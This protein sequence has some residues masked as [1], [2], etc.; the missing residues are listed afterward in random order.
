[1]D[2]SYV[3]D[4]TGW[5]T[6]TIRGDGQHATVTASYLHDSLKNLASA[7][8]LLLGGEQEVD[9]IF[10]DEPGEHHLVLQRLPNGEVGYE[11]RWYNHWFSWG[12]G[13]CDDFRIVLTG[14]TSI[15]QLQDCV[16]HV[17]Q[18]IL[19]TLGVEGYKAKWA[20][21]DFPI[22]EFEKLKPS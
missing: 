21:H 19:D 13:E 20:E 4:G 9:V 6:A 11:L 17:L 10:M 2:L 5:A 14:R 15:R 1:M 3:V 16:R 22:S 8:L 18:E 7:V 12:Y